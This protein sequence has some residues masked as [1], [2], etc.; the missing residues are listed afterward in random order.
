M[1]TNPVTRFT[2]NHHLL[3]VKDCPST[4]DVLAFTGSDALSV[5]FSYRIEFTSDN[6]AIGREMMLMKPASL[7][8]QAPV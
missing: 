7:T 5:P 3:S 2:H 8:L 1:S 4:T 6:H